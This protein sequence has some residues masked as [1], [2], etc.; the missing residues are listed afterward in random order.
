M[1]KKKWKFKKRFY[2]FRCPNW[3][4]SGLEK[5]AEKHGLNMTDTVRNGLAEY[6]GIER[7]KECIYIDESA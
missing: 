1:R 4:F 3:L 7:P 6:Y 2:Q 5:V